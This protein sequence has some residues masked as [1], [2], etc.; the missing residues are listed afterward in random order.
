GQR[1]AAD[2]DGAADVPGNGERLL[3][4]NLT[5]D[6]NRWSDMRNCPHA[7]ASWLRGLRQTTFP[8]R[9]RVNTCVAAREV[10]RC[11]TNTAVRSRRRNRRW[12]TYRRVLSLTCLSRQAQRYPPYVVCQI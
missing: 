10:S 9:D 5:L 8:S 3:G 4:A 1:V 11:V 6:R 7:V 12:S 2:V